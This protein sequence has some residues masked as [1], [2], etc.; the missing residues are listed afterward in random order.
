MLGVPFY[1]HGWLGVPDVNHGLYQ[2]STGAAPGTDE[3]GTESYRILK[4]KGY[5][6]YFQHAAR[7]A[8][9]Y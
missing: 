8:W 9:L 1:G 4:A 6:R 3:E 2:T 7:A 5:P